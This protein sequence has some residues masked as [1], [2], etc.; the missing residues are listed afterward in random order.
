MN[1]RNLLLLL[2]LA[3][4]LTACSPVTNSLDT[5]QQ[6]EAEESPVSGNNEKNTSSQTEEEKNQSSPDNGGNL[7]IGTI[8]E[9]ATLNPLQTVSGFALDQI[10][11]SLVHLDPETGEIVPYLAE[12]WEQAEDGMYWDF[13]LR[14]D[15]LFH[16]GTPCT[17]EDFVYTITQAKEPQNAS[18][19]STIL[20]YVKSAEA[21]DDYTLRVHMLQPSAL[22]LTNIA[23]PAYLQP[24]SKKYMEE[25]GPDEYSRNPIGVGPFMFKEWKTN[26]HIVLERNPDFVWGPE[27]THGGPA[28]LDSITYR[29]IPEYSTILAGL[30]AGELHSALNIESKD[31]ER[32]K[33]SGLDFFQT[34]AQGSIN[35][36]FFNVNKPP[37]DDIRVRKAFNMAVDREIMI[38]VLENSQAEL[39]YGPISPS[40][41]GYW[42]GVEE[43]G[44]TYNF[45]KAEELMKEAGYE[46]NAD[47]LLEKDGEILSLPLHTYDAATQITTVLQ[48][49]LKQL[50]V[51]TEIIQQENN[52]LLETTLSGEYSFLI[53]GYNWDEGV[54]LM[55]AMFHSS[56]IGVLNISQVNDPELDKILEAAYSATTLE[57]AY[58]YLAEA[59]EYVI[60]Q[61]YSCPL[62]SPYNNNAFS[63]EVKGIYEINSWPC[64]FD[65]YFVTK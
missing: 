60:E 49:H 50:G 43:L 24:I 9:P 19:L 54:G 7:V 48:E 28:Y 4:L 25:V 44:Y 30:E 15:V 21:L 35:S 40:V 59:Q 23:N 18:T 6:T 58:Q 39:M 41:L 42:S 33:V 65:T 26:E 56:M 61:A 32:L 20:Q 29:F 14:E 13:K 34:T 53:S 11:A 57:E 36:I 31:V 17:A 38:N 55:F 12:S 46:K 8:S 52:I 3:L 5:N 51:E 63:S 2:V 27:F 1:K 16:N 47:G 22:F 64:Y 45:E 37:F 62:Y 10:G